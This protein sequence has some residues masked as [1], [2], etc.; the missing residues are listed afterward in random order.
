[1]IAQRSEDC[2]TNKPR[3]FFAA[4]HFE[5]NAR[6]APNTFHQRAIVASFARSGRRN[7]AIIAHVM[8]VH[9]LAESFKRTC[10]ARNRLRIKKPARKRVMAQ[11]HRRPFVVENLNVV[12]GSRPRDYETNRV[13]ACVNRSE[14][15]RGGQFSAPEVRKCV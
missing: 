11:P 8:L 2:R 9:P 7:G 10:S 5:F 3:F 15:D 13:R 6:L 1:M 4:D 12:G 14:L